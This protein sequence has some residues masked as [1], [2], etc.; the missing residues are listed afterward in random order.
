MISWHACKLWLEN[1]GNVAVDLLG[2]LTLI[3]LVFTSVFHEGFFCLVTG[4]LA[5]HNISWQSAVFSLYEG[6]SNSQYF[7]C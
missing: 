2:I 1:F 3:T 6:E 5:D 4:L 7:E